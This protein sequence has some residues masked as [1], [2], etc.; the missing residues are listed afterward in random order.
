MPRVD[1]TSLF[2]NK[3]ISRNAKPKRKKRTCFGLY[4][5]TCGNCNNPL[6]RQ[7]ARIKSRTGALPGARLS[8]TETII[9]NHG[10][11]LSNTCEAHRNKR[12]NKTRGGP[13]VFGPMA[14]PA[15]VP[16]P[17]IEPEPPPAWLWLISYP[18]GARRMKVGA[19][20]E[21]CVLPKDTLAAPAP[22]PEPVRRSF[23]QVGLVEV[24]PGGLHDVLY[25]HSH[26]TRTL[27]EYYRRPKDSFT[28]RIS[29]VLLCAGDDCNE[30]HVARTFSRDGHHTLHG[31]ATAISLGGNGVFWPAEDLVRDQQLR[32]LQPNCQGQAQSSPADAMLADLG[33]DR[34]KIAALLCPA[35]IAQLIARGAWPELVA[36]GR[37]PRVWDEYPKSEWINE[38]KG[39]HCAPSSPVITAGRLQAIAADLKRWAPSIRSS[40]SGEQNGDTTYFAGGRTDGNFPME[41]KQ[42]EWMFL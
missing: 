3:Q 36:L 41:L 37:W 25:P 32:V 4:K 8:Q 7:Q 5:V 28:L 42:T 23:L 29:R 12:K 31:G 39:L 16:V 18:H 26:F 33:V 24:L 14:T 27:W 20:R 11:N 21:K 15:G 9:A 2:S 30:V 10:R 22:M 6:Q 40:G 13:L 38:N 17:E 19:H 1:N 35:P 34:E